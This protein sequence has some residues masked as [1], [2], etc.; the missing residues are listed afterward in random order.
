MAIART[1]K[2]LGLR[3]EASARFE[4]GCDPWAIEPSVQRFCQLLGESVPTLRVADGMLDVRGEVPEPFTVSVPIARVQR[5]IGVALDAEQI[6]RLLE[7][8][9]FTVLEESASGQVTV[10]VPTNRP[11]VRA[12]PYGVD[13]V[14]EEVARTFGYSHVPRRVPTWPQPGG[15]TRLQRSRAHRQGRAGRTRAPRRAGPTPS[16]PPTR[17]AD[18]GLTGEA[19]RVSEPARRGEAVPAPLPAARTVGRV[20]V[21]RQPAAGRHPPLRGRRRLL[22]PRRGLAPGGRARGR[23]WHGA[24]GAA[25]R[26]RAAGGRLRPGERRRAH[27]GGRLARAGG[28]VCASTTVRLVPPAGV[29]ATVAAAPSPACTPRAPRILV[30]HDASGGGVRARFGR[31]DRSRRRVSTLRLASVGGGRRRDG[32]AGSR[33]TSGCSSTRHACRDAPPWWAP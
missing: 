14:I 4:R 11:D 17:T 27:G 32:W 2:R 22:A 20:V 9:G 19:V 12:E 8:I 28:R 7:P 18:A 24:G 16:S 3:T 6:A 13:D 23:R 1:S 29:G 25:G 5:Q 15:L 31:R 30:A 10:L 21:Q 33:S 26:A